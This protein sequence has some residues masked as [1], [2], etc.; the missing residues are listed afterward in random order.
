MNT[1]AKRPTWIV[2]VGMA[3]KRLVISAVVGIAA[4]FALRLTDLAPVMRVLIG[5]DTGVLIYLVWATTVMARCSTV[6][7]IKRNAAIQDEGALAILLLAVGA[8]IASLGAILAELA[9][10]ERA[11]PHYGFHVA[12]AA[13][14]V[15]LSWTFTHTIFAL[16]YAHDFYGEASRRNGLNFPGNAKPDYWDFVYFSFVIGM[17]FQVSDVAVTN[18]AIR[19]MVVAHGALSFFFSTA[20]VALTVNI[21]AGL[22]QK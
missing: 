17:T 9:A 13:A 20:I 4:A 14:T 11:N 22:F 12:L 8:A 5:W 10:L 1:T 6:A 16:H 21:A 3:H 18:K 7:A 19:R 2:R 15:I